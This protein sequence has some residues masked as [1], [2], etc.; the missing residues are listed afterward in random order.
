MGQFLGS[1]VRDGTLL[2]G[3]IV[4]IVTRLEGRAATKYTSLYH[5]HNMHTY[6]RTYIHTVYIRM[7]IYAYVCIYLYV[8][9]YLHTYLHLHILVYIYL[10]TLTYIY[11]HT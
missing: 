6:A 7:Y 8:H 4:N 2:I 9:I 3:M 10:H 11:L 5:I 1:C